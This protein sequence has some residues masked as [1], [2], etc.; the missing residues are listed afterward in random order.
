MGKLKGREI[1]QREVAT[2][3][4]EASG[5]HIGRMGE[6][7]LMRKRITMLIAAA[8]LALTMAFAMAA[9][10]FADVRCDKERGITTCQHGN[11]GSITEQHH[12]AEGSSGSSV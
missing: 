7:N 3:R 10:S 12:G 11:A 9:P 4:Q 1:P 8:L 6:R 5:L 2:D